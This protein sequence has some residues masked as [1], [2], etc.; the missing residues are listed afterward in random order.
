[1]RKL[2]CLTWVGSLFIIFSDIIGT[3]I[4]IFINNANN[5]HK[6]FFYTPFIIKKMFLC[7]AAIE[8]NN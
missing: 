1:M 4:W 6:N 3:F 7:K 5:F 8:N 2:I